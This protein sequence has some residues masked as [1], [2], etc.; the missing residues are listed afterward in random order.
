[1]FRV[2]EKIKEKSSFLILLFLLIFLLI[3]KNEDDKIIYIGFNYLFYALYVISILIVFIFLIK[4]QGV[5][6]RIKTFLEYL[7]ISLF[8]G[9]ILCMIILFPINKYNL[10]SSLERNK[11]EIVECELESIS[12]RRMSRGFYFK[13]KNES[14]FIRGYLNIFNEIERQNKC[15]D[16]YVQVGISKGFL[17][18]YIID[19][20]IILLRTLTNEN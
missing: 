10:K 20:Y 17:N 18:S 14:H 6:K 12:K 4:L 5:I 2:K 8:F 7:L 16:Y 9:Y 1:M 19:S 15:E 13:F 11:I 3:F